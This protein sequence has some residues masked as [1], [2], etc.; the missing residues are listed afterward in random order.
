MQ[1]QQAY[2]LIDAGADVIIGHHPHT[3]QTVELYK[4]KPIY[5]SIGN[6]IFDQKKTINSKGLMI[7]LNVNKNDVTFRK[8]EFYIEKCTPKILYD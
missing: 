3:I 2:Q 8:T 5:Y 1:K 7:Q 4:E 6:F